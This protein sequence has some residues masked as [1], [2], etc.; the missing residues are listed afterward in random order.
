VRE[1]GGSSVL[2]YEPEEWAHAQT[3]LRRAAEVLSPGHTLTIAAPARVLRQLNVDARLIEVPLK[4]GRLGTLRR[5]AEYRR[6]V[7]TLNPTLALYMSGDRAVPFLA[8]MRPMNAKQAALV[9]RPR[10]RHDMQ[11][12]PSRLR[13]MLLLL[14]QELTISRWRLRE[15]AAMLLTL[16][17]RAAKQW[18][19]KRGVPVRWLPEPPVRA[20]AGDRTLQRRGI[21][22]Y[23]ALAPRKGLERL[24]AAVSILVK[25]RDDIVVKIAGKVAAGFEDDLDQIVQDMMRV[26]VQVETRFERLRE[27]EGIDLLRSAQVCV[28]PYVTHR[29]MSRVL[30]E[31]A[32]AGTKVVADEFGLL[33]HLVRTYKLG[34]AVDCG[35]PHIFARALDSALG[36]SHWSDEGATFVRRYEG[37]EF[38]RVLLDVVQ[39]TGHDHRAQA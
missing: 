3:Y 26:G 25:E 27:D 38:R 6:L 17:E 12:R 29:G 11:G 2:L 32:F 28:L 31:A 35:D 5:V 14:G 4:D 15:D 34:S 39:S 13:E 23:G 37:V 1:D 36:E 18:E 22:L 7:R 33:G 9:L 30:L 10:Y 20:A 21:V 24:V 19:S 16:D 8:G